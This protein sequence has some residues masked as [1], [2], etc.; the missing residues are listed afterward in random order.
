MQSPV[1]G[2]KASP[3]EQERKPLGP[4]EQV[5]F[6]ENCSTEGKLR[7]RAEGDK[8]S[9][10]D[11]TAGWH[12]RLDGHEFEQ[13]Q[14]LVKDREAWHAAVTGQDLATEEQPRNTAQPH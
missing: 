11:E 8:G 4:P 2:N 6:K 3:C 10:E 1:A 9:T 12:H 14:E 7:A 13:L 5:P